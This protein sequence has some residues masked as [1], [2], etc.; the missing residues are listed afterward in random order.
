MITVNS[1]PNGDE[2]I[3]LD[4][5]LYLPDTDDPAP[6]V[7]LA[8]GFGG[9][10]NTVRA[11]ARDLAKDGF[12]VLTWTARGFGR[13]SG[14]IHLNDPDY[15]VRDAQRLL[16]WLATQ[17]QVRKDAEN[18]PQVG[19]AGESYGGALALMLAGLDQRVDAIVPQITYND[20]G[21]SLL[22]N[23]TGAGA[24]QGVF[25]RMW[26]GIFFAGGNTPGS[27]P[28]CGRFAPNICELYQKV[29]TD[30]EGNPEAAATLRRLSPASVLPTVKAPTLLVQGLA[31]TLFPVTEANANAIG[32]SANGTPVKVAW[33]SGGHDGGEGP[34]ADQ[35]RIQELTLD[36][37]KYYVADEGAE[38]KDTFTY[39][40]MTGLDLSR[41]GI[42]STA[43]QVE[44]YPRLSSSPRSVA[45]TGSPQEI[46]NP[47]GGSPAAISA[48]PGLGQLGD[49]SALA[50]V[51]LDLPG[52]HATF[53]SQA[54][55]EAIDVVGSPTVR[56]KAASP[57]GEAVLFVKIYA[58]DADGRASLTNG[59]VAPVR[60]QNLPTDIANAQE[61]TVQLPGITRRFER[62]E[63]VRIVIATTDQGYASPVE[64]A[65]YTVDAANEVQLPTVDSSPINT[66]TSNLRWILA[67]LAATIVLGVIAAIVIAR[68]RHRKADR[69]VVEKYA[70][71]PLVV[72]GLRKEYSNGFV[73]VSEVSFKVERGQVV[74]LLGPNGA[75][76]TTS[77]RVLMG[78]T[79]PS[80][81]E[82]LV[83]GHHL[84]PGAPVLSRLGALV[85]GP[86]FLPH[87]SGLNNLR[88]YWESTG[89]PEADARFDEVIE[90]AG[91]GKAITRKMRTY[92]HGM[93]QRLAI[94]QAMLGLPDLLVLDE[95]TDGLD[96][97]Q[98]AQMRRVLQRYAQDGRA[99]LVSSHLLA[100]VEQTC[101]HAVVVS[102]GRVVA[103]GPV[104]EIV[105][106]GKDARRLEDAFLELVSS[107]DA[108]PREATR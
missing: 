20:L 95:P 108:D 80:A 34:K 12:V 90:I 5:S 1:G 63:K 97:P 55:S 37:L 22:P 103:S 69:S 4:T 91:L 10:K 42:S 105:G 104:A 2:P 89:R 50:E 59:Q 88:L 26:A 19:A 94:A 44:S 99:V 28:Q 47:A 96:P 53:D 102:R 21:N 49:L 41:Q 61:V 32:I 14:M 101:T 93:K 45:V 35:E 15:E 24:A 92:S 46:A 7:L 9:T 48:L 58:V 13:S 30:G 8:H 23:A 25:K 83:F 87:L 85:E 84:V 68:W 36:W 43:Y 98:I 74:G 75:G 81:G 54:L 71:T 27:N 77:L 6:A 39:S 3:S 73:A 17:P 64:P 66:T 106:E 70:E 51:S 107:R 11:Q 40:R 100:E 57:S 29:A 72:D 78:L 82:V 56:I 60:L 67:G 16:D 65:V 62:G 76:K 31:D 79:Q 86:G 18:D 38:P 52:Q 33:F